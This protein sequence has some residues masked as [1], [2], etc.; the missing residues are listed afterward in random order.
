MIYNN[1]LICQTFHEDRTLSLVEADI[2]ILCLD[3]CFKSRSKMGNALGVYQQRLR[4]QFELG[5]TSDHT[6]PIGHDT[7]TTH[8]SVKTCTMPQY[9]QYFGMNDQYFD[10]E[11]HV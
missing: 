11:L 2:C 3:Q 1:V 8:M 4:I 7:W 5:S 10:R 6:R 9:D